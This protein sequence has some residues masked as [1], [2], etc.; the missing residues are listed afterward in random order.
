VALPFVKFYLRDW[1]GDAQLMSCSL[2]AR[3]LLIHILRV[4]READPFGFFVGRGGEAIDVKTFSEHVRSK[5]REIRTLIAEL[6]ASGTL[7]R[8]AH[9]RLFSRR[10]VREQAKFEMDQA[11]GKSGGNPFLIGGG[12]PDGVNPMDK[13]QDKAHGIPRNQK[14]DISLS[15]RSSA[16]QFGVIPDDLPRLRDLSMLFIGAFANCR[17]EVKAEKHVPHYAAMLAV[18]RSRGITVVEAWHACGQALEIN[19][20]PLF[21]ASVKSAISFLPPAGAARKYASSPIDDPLQR[22]ILAAE[23]RR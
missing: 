19:G 17:D 23:D 4:M 22:K 7:S 18:M 1:E 12:K 6:E 9:S 16:E 21:G 20:R 3:G 8:D 13:A 5:P 10:L 11:N 14:L 2:A 15:L